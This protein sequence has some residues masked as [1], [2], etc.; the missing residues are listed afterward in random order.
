MED[1]NP[2]TL[3]SLF[4]PDSSSSKGENGQ[5][6]IMGGSGLF[7]GAPVLALKAA[8]R[9]VDMVFF[10]SPE[11][12]IGK[13]AAQLKAGLSS[14]IWVPFAQAEEYIGKSEAVLIGPGLMR[15][16]HEMQNSECQKKRVCDK[17]GEKTKDLTES[18]L[19]KFPRKQWVIDGGSLQVVEAG[20]LPVGAILTPN[21]REFKL[22][23]DLEPTPSNAQKMAQKYR[24]IVVLKLVETIVCSAKAVRIKGG[25]AGLAKGGTGDLLAGLITG[26]A[27]KNE[28]FLAACAGAYLLKK[29]ADEL[30]QKVGFAYNADDLAVQ[31]TIELG[32]YYR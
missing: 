2:Q 8:S 4:K 30:Y 21:R 23:F 26:L 27:A 10:S 1:F 6:T 22:L 28:P 29:A 17:E 20:F 24:C 16:R 9:L 31:I 32:N 11:P 19:R 15:F 18:L 3:A 12:E 14:F 25:N 7:H 13:V 5:I